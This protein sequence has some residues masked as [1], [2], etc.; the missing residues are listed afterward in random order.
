MTHQPNTNPPTI[1][2]QPPNNPREHYI[3]QNN[4]V[5]FPAF[6]PSHPILLLEANGDL[7]D[8]AK[9]GCGSCAVPWFAEMGAVARVLFEAYLQYCVLARNLDFGDLELYFLTGLPNTLYNLFLYFMKG[10]L[11]TF[12]IHILQCSVRAQSIFEH[13]CINKPSQELDVTATTFG[14]DHHHLL[15]TEGGSFFRAEVT[16]W[17]QFPTFRYRW[18]DVERWQFITGWGQNQHLRFRCSTT[19]KICFISS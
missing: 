5:D 7:G 6:Y 9:G 18:W 19:L 17:C 8:M 12:T 14:Q 10:T 16:M 11:S 4:T 15:T 2:I 13:L 1:A 3:S